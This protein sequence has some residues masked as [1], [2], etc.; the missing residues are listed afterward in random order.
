[1]NAYNIKLNGKWFVGVGEV[2]GQ[3]LVEVGTTRGGTLN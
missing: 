1:M 3:H 2:N